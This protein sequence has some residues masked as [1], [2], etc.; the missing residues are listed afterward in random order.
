MSITSWRV[1]GAYTKEGGQITTSFFYKV[2]F[3]DA[4]LE[5][6]VRT[7]LG[8]PAPTVITDTDMA[9]LLD[10]AVGYASIFVDTYRGAPRS[11]LATEGFLTAV[12]FVTL[13]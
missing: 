3:T 1:A 7:A 9:T 6:E 11:K 10:G 4:N 12:N 8:I 5:A 13:L 2:V